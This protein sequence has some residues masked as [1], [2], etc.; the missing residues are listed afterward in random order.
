MGEQNVLK[1]RQRKEWR[2]IAGPLP[3]IRKIQWRHLRA[4]RISG[5]TGWNF[6][7][8]FA[9]ERAPLLSEVIAFA[10]GSVCRYVSG[11]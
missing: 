9:G 3:V 10:N 2:R 11:I 7:S 5:Q 1:M 4:R 6:D 8:R